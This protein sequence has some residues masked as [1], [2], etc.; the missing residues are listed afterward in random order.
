MS[1]IHGRR[2]DIQALRAIAVLAVIA[3]HVAGWPN[4]G[5]VGVDVFFVISGFVITTGLWREYERNGRI[6]LRS[7]YVRRVK[8][9]LPAAALTVVATALAAVALLP[10]ERAVNAGI[11]GVW[12]L[13]AAA[14]LRMAAT[15]TDYFA[16]GL[17]PS[18]F[19]HFWSLSIEEQFYF[20]LPVLMVLLLAFVPLRRSAPARAMVMISLGALFL[21]S[22]VVGIV[23]TNVLERADAYFSFAV[24]AWELGAGVL[25]A[26]VAPRLARLSPAARYAAMV[27]GAGLIAIAVFWF[28][29]DT[30]FPGAAA[31]LPVLGA[32]LVIAAGTNA[33]KA[34]RERI[35]F[36]TAR[37]ISYIGDLS[38]SLYLWHFPVVILLLAILPVGPGYYVAC[39]LATAGLAVAGYH[40]V[41]NPLRRRTWGIEGVVQRSSRRGM[42]IVGA[43][44]GVALIA[45]F[46]AVNGPAQPLLRA[47]W[48]PSTIASPVEESFDPG[49]VECLGAEWLA[50][51]C[52]LEP[53]DLSGQLDG[54][55]EDTGGSYDCYR[56]DGEEP[57]TCE[58]GSDDPGA[59][60]VA[61]IGDSHAA[62]YIPTL[63]A[64]AD[65]YGWRI[66]T[67]VGN[68]C[69]WVPQS[70][71]SCGEQIDLAQADFTDSTPYDVIFVASSRDATS[72]WDADRVDDAAR[73]WNDA[74]RAGSAIAVIQDAPETDQ[75]SL[76]CVQRASGDKA[77][78][79]LAEQ[80]A[81]SRIDGAQR[82]AEQLGTVLIETEDLFCADGF[83]AAVIGDVAVYRD[84]SGHITGTYALSMTGQL[85]QK[86]SQADLGLI[87]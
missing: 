71:D 13:L 26:L 85:A 31:L 30:A 47:N 86:I 3:H 44:L 18:P 23:E 20:L 59:Q 50:T 66:T 45:G 4:G 77:D 32:V 37:P 87:G 19:Q 14:N 78:C 8:R 73:L 5:F 33:P 40:G 48:A 1:Q 79:G 24:R 22:L 65:Q 49:D 56:A 6:S 75:E 60:Q 7:F 11:D 55:S 68:G 84:A 46:A 69:Q 52:E 57:R 51:G 28:T 12:S 2:R 43:V 25:L 64:L 80:E 41:E 54:V 35:R 36:V 70:D 63:R 21:L 38:Y 72:V 17:V 34:F 74:E 58:Y 82:V 39:L 53:H 76:S 10:R 15:E 83:C 42:R 16:E 62:M 9:I 81:T 29:P 27:A 67:Y 61:I